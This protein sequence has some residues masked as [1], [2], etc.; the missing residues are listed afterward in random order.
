MNN[1]FKN[2]IENLKEEEHLILGDQT[3]VNE[4]IFDASIQCSIFGTL[5]FFEVDFQEIDFTGSTIVNC[6]F[7]NCRFKD[8]TFRKCDFWNSTFENCQI[9]TSNFT[10]AIFHKGSSALHFWFGRNYK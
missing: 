1:K 5:A 8:V 6:Q 4:R 10:R 7:K 9:E 2:I 3:F